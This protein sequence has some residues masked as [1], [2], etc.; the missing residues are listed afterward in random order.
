MTNLALFD[1]NASIEVTKPVRMID[2]VEFDWFKSFDQIYVELGPSESTTVNLTLVHPAPPDPGTYSMTI[3]ATDEDFDV[4]SQLEIYFDVPVLAQPGVT[5]SS[6]EIQVDSQ[7]ITNTSVQIHNLGNGAQTTTS[8]STPRRMGRRPTRARAFPGIQA[9]FDR[10]A[11]QGG[12]D[13]R[14]NHDHAP[15]VLLTAG[16]TF[17][18]E[19]KVKSRVSS[20][21]WTFQMPMVIQPSD[22]LGLTPESGGTQGG[23]GRLAARDIRADLQ[24]GQQGGDA[25]HP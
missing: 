11:V 14:W 8:S 3:T 16:S 23:P 5:P 1:T 19:I 10:H 18:A 17:F 22:S 6:A 12:L 2:G 7:E 20:E 25:H 15:G 24:P 4:E 21:V 9:G 13:I